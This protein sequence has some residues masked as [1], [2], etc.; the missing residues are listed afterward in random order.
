MLD[1]GYPPPDV[2]VP[3]T[4]LAKQVPVAWL[5][6]IEVEAQRLLAESTSLDDWLERVD[7]ACDAGLD[8]GAAGLKSIIAYRSGLG[9][10]PV[11]M[12]AAHAAYGHASA[13]AAGRA[14]RCA[15]RRSR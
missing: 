3:H 15:C 11:D 7:A 8:A 14:R 9:V 13:A 2:V 10:S 6:R 1:T 5:V 12:A 4:E